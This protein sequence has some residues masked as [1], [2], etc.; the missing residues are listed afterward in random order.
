V[1]NPA[2][3]ARAMRI[4][5]RRKFL[6]SDNPSCFY[7]DEPEIA[8]LEL[9]HPVGR[10]HDKNFTRI[11]CRNCHRKLELRRDVAQL[12]RNG[13]RQAPED[14]VESL[15]NYL[16]R[17]AEDHEAT[18][19]SLRRKARLFAERRKKMQAGE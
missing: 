14:D 11:V 6:G 19:E 12:T 8:C 18:S 16:M 17:M 2:P 15:L 13:R 4:E 3:V 7:C 1:K 10:E 9:E 5:M